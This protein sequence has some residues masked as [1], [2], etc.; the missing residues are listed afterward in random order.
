MKHL[1]TSKEIIRAKNFHT[2]LVFT[3]SGMEIIHLTFGTVY[4]LVQCTYLVC[5]FWIPVQ[6]VLIQKYTLKLLFHVNFLLRPSVKKVKI[7]LGGRIFYYRVKRKCYMEI[8][9]S[10]VV[11]LTAFT[12]AYSFTQGLPSYYTKLL[13]Q[14]MND[15]M[16]KNNC[17]IIKVKNQGF[18]DIQ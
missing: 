3:V 18:C 16:E 10:Q 11:R 13:T 1:Q 5:C 15:S 8:S 14:L 2:Y 12:A 4:T 7:N 9:R 6:L 17:Y